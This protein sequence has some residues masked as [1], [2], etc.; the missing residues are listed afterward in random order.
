MPHLN[1]THT[2][3][4]DISVVV[5]FFNAEETLSLCIDGLMAQS[6]TSFEVILIDN[7]SSDRST[8]IAKDT[9]RAFPDR[10]R[11]IREVKQGA[12]SARNSGVRHASGGIICFTDADCIPDSDW[13]AGLITPFE[14]PKIGAVAGRLVGYGA[15]T[16]FDKFHFLFTLKG[17]PK[18][19]QFDEFL[20]ARGGFPT[21]NLAVRKDIFEQ[22]DGFDETLRIVGE[23]YDLCARIYLAGYAIQYTTDAVTRHKHRADLRATWRQAAQYGF[24]HA[25]LLARY[26]KR[27]MIIDL[28]RYSYISRRWPLRMWL[29][30]ASADKKVL[31]IT[32]ISIFFPLFFLVLA[33]YLIFLSMD[34]GRRLSLHGITA[35]F[36]EKCLLVLLLLVKSFAMT[37]G[38]LSGSIKYKVFCF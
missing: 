16:L 33:A 38:R 9:C 34:I 36:R 1:S 30:L 25:I 14:N 15:D 19:E 21:A 3:P 22:I 4:F 11:Y 23:D 20:V 35:C 31:A 32:G 18:S 28:P 10:F 17:L 5:P 24:A 7:N 12:A 13:L 29:N 37:I 6:Y 2:Q 26:F 27:L 8:T